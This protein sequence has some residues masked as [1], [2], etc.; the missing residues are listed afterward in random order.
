MKKIAISFIVIL[1]AAQLLL[2]CSPDRLPKKEH[3]LL[4]L[5]QIP[6]ENMN[7][8]AELTLPDS[9]NSYQFGDPILLSLVN[10][11][12]NALIFPADYGIRLFVND[13]ESKDWTELDNLTEYAHTGERHIQPI[14]KDNTGEVMFS[15]YPDTEALSQSVVV[16][17]VV[18]GSTA[19]SGEIASEPVG[20]YIEFTI[21]P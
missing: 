7:V 16:R 8:L 21:S 5:L 9:G 3:N 17:V 19:P 14:S 20:A 4:E 2:A 6:A 1:F 18:L 15:V 10:K 12:R 11:S 13:A